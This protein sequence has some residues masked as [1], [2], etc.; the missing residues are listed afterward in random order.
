MQ[1]SNEQTKF[2]TVRSAALMLN[3]KNEPDCAPAAR[4]YLLLAAS[5]AKR[6]G[7][8]HV[9]GNISRFAQAISGDLA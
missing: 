7:D 3:A 6:Q 8:K 1:M 4:K 9:L 2:L 5:Y